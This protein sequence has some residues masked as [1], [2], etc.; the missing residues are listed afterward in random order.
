MPPESIRKFHRNI[1]SKHSIGTFHQNIPTE[2]SIRT[3]QQNIPS[4]HSIRKFHRNI[5]SEHSIRKFPQNIPWEHSIRKFHLN[6]PS[7]HS[8]RTF[9][10]DIPTLQRGNYMIIWRFVFLWSVC[11]STYKER[12]CSVCGLNIDRKPSGKRKIFLIQFMHEITRILITT[13]PSFVIFTCLYMVF[14]YICSK[15]LENIFHVHR[16]T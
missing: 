2:H 4:E 15:F 9:H 14:C 13:F 12:R 8:I 7:E 1:S 16:S 6:I 10:R 3:F 5:P 11:L